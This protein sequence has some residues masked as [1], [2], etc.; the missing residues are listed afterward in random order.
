MRNAS[1]NCP[2]SNCID[3]NHINSDDSHRY[4]FILCKAFIAKAAK[5]FPKEKIMIRHW[6]K[7]KKKN[8]TTNQ[9]HLKFTTPKNHAD[10][11]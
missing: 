7:K 6:T 11:T 1:V 2:T 10:K 5:G 3:H 9:V 8:K 4:K